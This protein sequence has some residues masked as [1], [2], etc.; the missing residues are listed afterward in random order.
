MEPSSS[1]TQPFTPEVRL[2]SPRLGALVGPEWLPPRFLDAA[3]ISVPDTLSRDTCCPFP[4][5]SLLIR[6]CSVP[7][8]LLALAASLVTRALGL[9]PAR[10]EQEDAGSLEVFALPHGRVSLPAHECTILY[11]FRSTVVTLNTTPFSQRII[12]RRWE[13]GQLPMLS[14]SIPA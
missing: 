3:P 4:P 10:C 9:W 5:S 6:I 12:K 14:P 8:V 2:G 7:R 11:L 1:E 13:K